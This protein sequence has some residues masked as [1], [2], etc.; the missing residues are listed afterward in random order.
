MEKDLKKVSA[1][2]LEQVSGGTNEYGVTCPKCGGPAT[3]SYSH[4]EIGVF[5]CDKCGHHFT[6]GPD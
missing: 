3:L 6:V 4:D 2:N 5:D 1:E